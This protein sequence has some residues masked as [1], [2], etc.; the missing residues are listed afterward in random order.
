MS[1]NTSSKFKGNNDLSFSLGRIN[2]LPRSYGDTRIIVMPRD[3]M[4]FYAYWE[5]AA[6]AFDGLKKKLGETKLNASRWV[7]RV[8]D[9]TGVEFNGSNSNKFFDIGITPDAVNWY[10]NVSEANRVWVVDLGLITPDGEFIT[11]ARSNVVSMPRTGVSS[12]TDEHWG[13]LHHEFE[14]LLKL[15]GV[16][17]IG[18]SSYDLVKL[19][20]EHWQEIVSH[21][22]P[23]SPSSFIS[24]SGKSVA[25]EES[26]QKG[27]WLKAD[28]EIIVYGATESDAKLTLSGQPLKLRPDGSFTVRFYL[29]DG[30]Q[31][32]RIEA[33]SADG[34]MK[35]Q[36]T[37][38]VNR[39][40]K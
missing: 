19:M 38:F 7:L 35:K 9:I 10:V 22:L 31:E 3:P 13:V 16:D 27:F 8:Y 37:F 29:P 5:V 23:S 20:K 1:E 39:D 25:K 33:T 32:Y 36:I 2:S 24:S 21:S 30:N 11:V 18:Q 28:T 15:S 4:W 6:G 34:T 12:I 14:R 17:K 26:K 40:T